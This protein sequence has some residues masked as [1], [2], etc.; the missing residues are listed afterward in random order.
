MWVL[1]SLSGTLLNALTVLIG[2]LMG[3]F[4]GERL[5]KRI[6][7]SLFGVLGLF[8][9]L[10]GLLDAFTTKSP[11]VL[12]GSLLLGTLIGEWLNLEDQLNRFGDTIQRKLARPGSTV[13][14]AFVTSTL[15]FCIGPLSIL[16]ALDNG[17]SGD[18]TKLAIKAVLDGF[19]ALAFSAA[20]GWGVLLS[21]FVI[22]AYQGTI[23]LCAGILAP[24]LHSN[25]ATIT[26]LT[27]TGGL[28][29]VAIGL[30]LLKIRDLRVANLIP[31]LALAP[32]IVTLLSV[33]SNLLR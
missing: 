32:A 27:A 18:I 20:L 6:H 16:G 13:S 9:I 7:D 22:L 4:L 15:V 25:P 12:L 31:A 23:S 1:E 19:A 24:I 10:I 17:L 3:V 28:I 30:K 5:P 29:L 2:G 14:E 33:A 21:V 8:T 11:L 26:E